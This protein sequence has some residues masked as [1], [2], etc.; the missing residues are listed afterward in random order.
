MLK[1]EHEITSLSDF[2]FEAECRLGWRPLRCLIQWIEYGDTGLAK[3]E[4]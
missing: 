4:I 2:V 1:N 3:R